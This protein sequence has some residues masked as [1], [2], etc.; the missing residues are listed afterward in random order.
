VLTYIA[1]VQFP[2]VRNQSVCVFCV[3]AFLN[4]VCMMLLASLIFLAKRNLHLR[5]IG[6]TNFLVSCQTEWTKQVQN[7]MAVRNADGGFKPCEI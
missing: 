2:V 7:G 1:D 5:R 6:D 4:A 3:V